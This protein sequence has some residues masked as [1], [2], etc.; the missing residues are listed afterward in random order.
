MTR[1]TGV[2]VGPRFY[3]HVSRQSGLEVKEGTMW[4]NGRK[5][6]IQRRDFVVIATGGGVLSCTRRRDLERMIFLLVLSQPW[7]IRTISFFSY[8]HKLS[9]PAHSSH[10]LF[11]PSHSSSLFQLQTRFGLN[12][13]NSFVPNPAGL[14]LHSHY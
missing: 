2:G 8:H 3:I 5:G 10:A 12:P 14:A 7:I 1:V 11:V 13:A 9:I 4:R 6:C